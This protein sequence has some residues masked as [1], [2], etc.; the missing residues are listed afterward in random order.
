MDTDQTTV[1]GQGKV[2]LKDESLDI[3]L[4]P[5]PKKGLQT[6]IFGKLSLSFGELAKP[7]KLGGT[8]ADPSFT[9]DP[10]LTALTFGKALGGVIL[11]GPLGI[12]AALAGRGSGPENPCLAA[13]EAARKGVKVSEDK[14]PE[15]KKSPEKKEEPA[16]NPSEGIRRVFEG[17][18]SSVKKLFCD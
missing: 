18:S 10:T 12:A 2:N 7:L 6:G 3:A 11:F 17:I 5:S 1:I 13:I 8:L 16:G 9:L 4:N 15:T 14:P